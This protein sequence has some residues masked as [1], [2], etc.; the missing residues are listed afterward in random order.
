[1]SPTQLTDILSQHGLNLLLGVT[2]LDH[3]TLSTIDRTGCTEFRE[4]EL[5]DVLW[6]PVHPSANVGNVGKQR[7]LCTV[8]CHLRRSDRVASLLTREFG[9]VR[10]QKRE[11]AAE[12]LWCQQE[13]VRPLERYHQTHLG[14]LVISV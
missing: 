11:E 6:L 2:T 12:E 5:D 14:I 1:M 9:V 10:V 7:L 4:Q 8:T 3:Q 13:H